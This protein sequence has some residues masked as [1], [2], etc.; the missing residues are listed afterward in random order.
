MSKQSENVASVDQVQ[1]ITPAWPPIEML[2]HAAFQGQGL[3]ARVRFELGLNR[4]EIYVRAAQVQVARLDA[5]VAEY[6]KSVAAEP[7]TAIPDY[8]S[9]PLIANVHFYFICWDAVAKELASLR[10]NKAGLLTPR[11]VWRKYRKPLER[12]QEAR[13]HLEH[14]SERLPMGKHSEWRHR[15]EDEFETIQGDPGAVRLGALFTINGEE[16]DV[17]VASA[18][19]LESLWEDL[20]EGLRSESEVSFAAWLKRQPL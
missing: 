7:F 12:Y 18:K 6:L 17:S 10:A 5:P 15:R 16:W 1:A 14:Y 13:N 3:P 11:K 2:L 9:G 8:P 4:I 19:V 20:V